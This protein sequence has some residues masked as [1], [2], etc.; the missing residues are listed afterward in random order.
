MFEDLF[1]DRGTVARY[2]SAPLL[3]ERLSYLTHCAQVGLR[4]AT[5]RSIAAY[6]TRLVRLLVA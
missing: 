1:V 5:L 6:Q 2:S 4:P 3:N